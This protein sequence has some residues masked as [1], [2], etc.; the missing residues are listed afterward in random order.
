MTFSNDHLTP[1][2]LL[3]AASEGLPHPCYLEH[4]L[5]LLY[6]LDPAPVRLFAQRLSSDSAHTPQ[7]RAASAALQ[8]RPPT[9][10]TVLTQAYIG[11]SST[12]LP[13]HAEPLLRAI[14]ARSRADALLRL[15]LAYSNVSVAKAAAALSVS[16]EAVRAICKEAGWVVEDGFVEIVKSPVS[17]PSGAGGREGPAAVDVNVGGKRMNAEESLAALAEMTERLVRLQD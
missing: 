6:T 13:A 4:M 14:I 9:L 17:A 12:P 11:P 1:R 15:A 7:L 8:R 16:E 2:S 3:Q 5:A 10:H